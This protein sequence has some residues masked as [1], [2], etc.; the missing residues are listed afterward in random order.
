MA[1]VEVIMP[2][3]GE[4]IAEGTIIKWHKKIGDTVV[5]DE[6]ILEIS[7]DKVD[8]EI[9][10]PTNGVLKAILVQENE[11]V[12]V[13]TVIAHIETDGS[14]TTEKESD[15]EEPA[16]EAEIEAGGAEVVEPEP[17][18]PKQQDAGPIEKQKDRFYSPL[19]LNIARQENVGMNELEAI[20]GS[21]AGGRVTKKDILRYIED[22]KTGNVSG[23]RA[24]AAEQVPAGR[25]DASRG[26]IET[27]TMDTM[28]RKIAEHMV[29]SVKTSPHVSSVTEADLSRIYAYRE[30]QRG[31]F[32]K[33]EGFKLTY[34]PFIIDAVIKALK[35]FPLVNSSIDG[36]KILIKKFINIG[37]AVAL[38]NGL[39]VPVIKNADEKNL[40]GLARAVNDLAVRARN[41]KLSPDDVQGGTFTIT[42]PGIF[43]NLWGTPIINQP[44]VAILGVGAIKKRPVVVDDMIA[45]KPMVY[46]NMSYDHRI[47]D[48]SLGGMFLQKVVEYLENFDDKQSI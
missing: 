29:Q 26:G 42:N 10:A 24:S 40:T 30:K 25:G 8:S 5:K 36:E 35:R 38:E 47:I 2:Q 31:A 21:G 19:V 14:G 23:V 28:R 9:P 17:Q 18:T 41:K 37:I 32:E 20:P 7:T 12:E 13:Q 15:A 4:S 11:T 43:G 33:R 45:I 34:T 22:R 48:G 1:I 44:Q 3:M 27:V 6:T 46:I 16:T 39:I